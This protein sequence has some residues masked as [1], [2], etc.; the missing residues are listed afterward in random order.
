MDMA[1]VEREAG[2]LEA[3]LRT[4][5]RNDMVKRERERERE[6]EFENTNKVGKISR[7]EVD[8]FSFFCK[9]V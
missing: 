1:R 7:V 8:F 3:T 6:R 2:R 5:R 4:K 9:N